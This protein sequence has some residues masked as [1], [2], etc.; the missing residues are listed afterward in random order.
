[1]YDVTDDEMLQWDNTRNPPVASVFD[2]VIYRDVQVVWNEEV[3]KYVSAPG[4]VLSAENY[5]AP[6]GTKCD[7][8]T[9]PGDYGMRPR[10]GNAVREAS[11][12]SFDYVNEQ[13]GAYMRAAD[14]DR[15]P[16][17]VDGAL[18]QQD[19]SDVIHGYVELQVQAEQQQ[20]EQKEQAE[21]QA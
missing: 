5:V 3:G 19:P 21:A 16:L 1:M 14:G 7:T 2:D 10:D 4:Q 13:T 18:Q 11:V 6:D 20:L 12:D 17:L 15:T 9:C 8:Q